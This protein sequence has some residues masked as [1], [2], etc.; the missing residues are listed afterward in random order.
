M[1]LLFN[2]AQLL[3][4]SVGAARNENVAGEI[5]V[6]VDGQFTRVDGVIRMLHTDSGVWIDGILT[7]T[8]ELSCSRCLV[9]FG[10]WTEFE[11][12][13]LFQS[14][15]DIVTG[16]KLDSFENTE[17][18]FTI[19]DQHLLDISE[20]VRQYTVTAIPIQPLCS[21][22]CL[23]FC[24][25]CGSNLNEGNCDCTVDLDPIWAPLRSLFPS[26]AHE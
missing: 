1:S 13:D 26:Y 5:P 24:S 2:V 3:K 8:L 6:E 22:G 11:I 14:T 10:R 20:S 15:V 9:A 4:E 7:A 12:N 17:G 19:D 16:R 23:G 25:K 21:D 18:Q